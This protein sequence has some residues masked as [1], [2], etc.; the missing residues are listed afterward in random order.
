MADP[1]EAWVFHVAGV[2][3]A[4]GAVAHVGEAGAHSAVWVAQRV[5]DDEFVIIANRFIVR[6]VIEVAADSTTQATHACRGDAFRH[7][8]NLFP[9]AE[10]LGTLTTD[11]KP[12]EGLP[13]DRRGVRHLKNG[14]RVV[15]FLLVFGGDNEPT[16]SPYFNDRIW[17]TLS[18]FASDKTWVW[19]PPTPLATDVYPFSAKPSRPLTR[20]DF[21]KL[22]RDV[23]RGAGPALDLTRGLAAGPW[24]DPSRYDIAPSA[25]LPPAAGG[26]NPRAISMFRT[27]YSFVIEVRLY[28]TA[29]DSV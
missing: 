25:A 23:Y 15:D 6:D 1:Q 11:P 26:N 13:R 10:Y 14:A 2:P 20:S 9:L 8:S 5:P 22:T 28:V 18:L 19:P 4:V 24:G 27:S 7:S 12:Y 29:C 16:L 17:R 21:V 3:P